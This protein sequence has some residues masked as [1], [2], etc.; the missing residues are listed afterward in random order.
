MRRLRRPPGAGPAFPPPPAAQRGS[1]RAGAQRPALGEQQR[2][3]RAPAPAAPVPAA[4]RGQRSAGRG[5]GE[6]GGRRCGAAALRAWLTRGRVGRAGGGVRRK[7]EGLECG[8]AGSVGASPAFVAG[9][10]VCPT[11]RWVIAE[12]VCGG[13][14]N[15]AG[16]WAPVGLGL[17]KMFSL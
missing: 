7:V 8:A 15:P 12:R 16:Q 14:A 11:R 17:H 3:G 13:R 5:A 4:G 2:L 10:S 6:A 9:G 1:L